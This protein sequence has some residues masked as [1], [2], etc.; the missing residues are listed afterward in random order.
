MIKLFGSDRMW[1]ANVDH[2]LFS[3]VACVSLS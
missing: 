2:D 1:S 3:R